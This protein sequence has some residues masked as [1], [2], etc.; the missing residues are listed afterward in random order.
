MQALP[1]EDR[2]A[3]NE[4]DADDEAELIRAFLIPEIFIFFILKPNV[5]LP[6]SADVF[7]KRRRQK[8]QRMYILFEI[9]P[10]ILILG[11]LVFG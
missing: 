9:T 2:L 4:V 8:T 1:D 7:S 11:E 5:I 3:I 10:T 6:F